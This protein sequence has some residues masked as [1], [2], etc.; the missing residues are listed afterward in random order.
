[1]PA[2]TRVER[3]SMGPLE[4]P[5]DA[6]WGAQTQRAVQ[7]FPASG[8]KMPRAFIRALGLIKYAAAGAN[9]ELGDL[10]AGVAHAIQS[11]SAEV[12]DGRWDQEFPV[13][14]FQTG[15]GTSS[16]MNANEV[17]ATLASRVLGAKV[18]PNDQ[19]N[20]S[21]SSNDVVPSAIH[22][23]AAL[24]LRD[25]LQPALK[26]LRETLQRRAV[27]LSDV[28]K[29][30]RTHL[31]DAMPI[32]LGQE[33]GGWAAQIAS[34]ELRLRGVLPRLHALAQG[35][36]AVGTGINARPEFAATFARHLHQRSG[37][38][39]TPAE[40]FFEALSSQDTAVE[41]SGLLKVL[42]VSLM[43][44]ANDLRWMNS[45]PLAGLGEIA[46]PALQPGS[47]I[48]PG[49]VNPVVAEA[50][51]MIAAQVIGNDA[52]I[53]IAGQSGNFQLNLMLPLIVHNLVQSLHLLSLAAVN[54][55]DHA[56][57]DLRV[58]GERLEDAVARN[59]ILVT[60][61][62]PV[63]GYEKGAAIAKKA[64]AEGRPI[65]DVAAEMTDLSVE[66]LRRLLD[67]KALTRGGIGAGGGGG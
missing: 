30:G 11:A 57:K 3:D 61:L 51:T 50:V 59:P 36:T 17:I 66:E 56:I 44:I 27:A 13:D 49:K 47:S 45:G 34:S 16:N 33:L 2:T 54:L 9:Q 60:A 28:V 38:A 55:A 4:V 14:V 31:M 43:K 64:Y 65:L 37:I 32:T 63:I 8:L 40:N 6:L 18:H 21:Q 12:I 46:L 1:M 67:P 5:A 26:H 58:N 52:A 41:L 7:N 23:A 42:A 53:T 15:S 48:M 19:V 10:G 35:G 20:M 39:F 25:E 24:A 22:I 62:N 29:T